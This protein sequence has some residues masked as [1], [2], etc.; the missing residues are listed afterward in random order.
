MSAYSGNEIAAR[1]I[2]NDVPETLFVQSSMSTEQSQNRRNSIEQSDTE[3]PSKRVATQAISERRDSGNQLS[4]RNHSVTRTIQTPRSATARKAYTTP[5]R[6]Q[7]RVQSEEP[8]NNSS[9]DEP[10]YVKDTGKLDK[11]STL[12]RAARVFLFLNNCPSNEDIA[13]FIHSFYDK[14]D[15]DGNRTLCQDTGEDWIQAFNYIRN[16]RSSWKN[17]LL[18]S[19]EVLNYMLTLCNKVPH[20]ILTSPGPLP[21]S[22]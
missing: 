14:V 18:H 12:Q 8:T 7:R 9:E 10:D 19:L 2:H 11:Y 5:R 21:Q 3:R 15:E 4:A 17:R 13:D 16:S 6:Q 20:C 22:T 1:T